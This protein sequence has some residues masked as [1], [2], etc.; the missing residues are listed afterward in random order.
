[1]HSFPV[2]LNPSVTHLQSYPSEVFMHTA[3]SSQSFS[4]MHSSLSESKNNQDQNFAPFTLCL[5]EIRGDG[6]YVLSS[7]LFIIFI[8][9]TQNTENTPDKKLHCDRI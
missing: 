4:S 9:H 1:M 2:P 6:R 3:S 5:R 7:C 8:C